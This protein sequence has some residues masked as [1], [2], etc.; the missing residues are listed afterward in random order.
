[1]K[2]SPGFGNAFANKK[3]RLFDSTDDDDMIGANCINAGLA[4]AWH[5]MGLG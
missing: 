4:R 1:L 5:G 2:V 3:R